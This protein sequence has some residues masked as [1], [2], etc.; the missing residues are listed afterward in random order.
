MRRAIL[1]IAV[2]LCAGCASTRPAINPEGAVG[3]AWLEPSGAI[4]VKDNQ[5]AP[6]EIGGVPTR[7]SAFGLGMTYGRVV[8][9]GATLRTSLGWDHTAQT[10]PGYYG[11]ESTWTRDR[12]TLSASMRFYLGK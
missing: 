11:G 1:L 7:S 12:T 5:G 3:T 2:I 4:Q 10:W 9:P 6:A 8:S